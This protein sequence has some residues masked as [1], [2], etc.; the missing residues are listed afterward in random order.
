M[1]N[2]LEPE[3]KALIFRLSKQGYSLPDIA[4]MIDRHPTTVSRHRS[5]M[6][7]CRRRN[8]FEFLSPNG[9]VV[10]VV[11]LTRFCQAFNLSQGNMSRVAQGKFQQHKGWRLVDAQNR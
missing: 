2:D 1:R 6:G 9:R 5:R 3:K 10:R 7:V 11:N 4:P 8:Y